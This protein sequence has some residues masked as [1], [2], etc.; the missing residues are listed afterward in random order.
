M[1]YM[2]EQMEQITRIG[3]SQRQ[4]K[5]SSHKLRQRPQ[6]QENN[7]V[8]SKCIAK[9]AYEQRAQVLRVN[10]SDR[11]RAIGVVKGVSSKISKKAD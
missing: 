4:T 6:S 5:Q 2:K 9:V 11:Y 8:P 7:T 10:K 1:K 3:V